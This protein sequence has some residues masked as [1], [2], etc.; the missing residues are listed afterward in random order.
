MSTGPHEGFRSQIVLNLVITV[1]GFGA[2]LMRAGR[3]LFERFMVRLVC[4]ATGGLLQARWTREHS[5]RCHR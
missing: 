2:G 1:A 5:T 3:G 4:I